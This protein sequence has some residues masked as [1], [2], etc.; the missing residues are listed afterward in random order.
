MPDRLLSTVRH[1]TVLPTGYRRH[2]SYQSMSVTLDDWTAARAV[3]DRRIA[4]LTVLR[5]ERKVAEGR[6]EWP[7]ENCCVEAGGHG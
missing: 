5:D 2:A 7:P 3:L 6:G 1:K 4:A